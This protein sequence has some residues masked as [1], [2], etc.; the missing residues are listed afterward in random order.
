MARMFTELTRR[1]A[2]GAT[3]AAGMQLAWRAA[4]GGNAKPLSLVDTHTHFYD[5]ARP[6]GVPWPEKSDAFLYRTVLP[7]EYRKVS[8][9]HGVR[10]TIVV[11]ASP[12]VEDN[13]WLLDLA[14]REPFILGVVGNLDPASAEFRR[15]LSRFSRNPRFRGIRSGATG[16]QAAVLHPASRANLKSL[17]DAGLVWDLNISV[18]QLAT[19]AKVAQQVPDLQIVINHLANVPIAPPGLNAEWLTGMRAAAKCPNIFCK[20]SG[21]VEGTATRKQPAPTDPEYYRETLASAWEIFGPHRT[22]YGS[23]WPVSARFAPYEVVQRIVQ[24]W[25]T[26][27][28]P[29]FAQAFFQGNAQRVYQWPTHQ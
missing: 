22:L 4:P 10:G 2:L 26:D 16:L 21:L 14:E 24:H 25:A 3:M 28:G 27:R 17:A 8:E 7:A 9:P 13:Q 18:P 29:V 19:V 20:V 6:R 23:N 12:W 1:E 11:E 15:N 5:P